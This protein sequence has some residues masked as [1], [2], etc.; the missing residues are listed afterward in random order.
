MQIQV[1]FFFDR[2]VSCCSD[3]VC[4]N[5]YAFSTNILVKSQLSVTCRLLRAA[6]AALPAR[7]LTLMLAYCGTLPQRSSFS[8]LL[9]CS[10]SRA[11][12]FHMSSESVLLISVKLIVTL[13]LLPNF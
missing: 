2:C 12:H 8:K 4:W 6:S 1:H 3:L 5:D 10:R 11:M 9:L 13:E 7:L